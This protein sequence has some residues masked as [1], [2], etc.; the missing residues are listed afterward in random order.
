MPLVRICA[1]GDQRWSSLPRPAGE[2]CRKRGIHKE[3]YYGWRKKYGGLSASNL[4][5]MRQLEQET[6]GFSKTQ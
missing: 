2:L 3:T 1:G 4:Q 5:Q 6:A